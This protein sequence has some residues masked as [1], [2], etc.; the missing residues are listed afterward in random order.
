MDPLAPIFDAANV[1]TLATN[2]T[3]LIVAMIGVSLLF[4]GARYV[5]RAIGARK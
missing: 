5:Y 3:T 2:T 1:S 4:V